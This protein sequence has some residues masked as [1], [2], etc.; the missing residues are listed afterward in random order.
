MR[1]GEGR[2]K[3]Q[4][5]QH[6]NIVDGELLGKILLEDEEGYE[7][8][9]CERGDGTLECGRDDYTMWKQTVHKTV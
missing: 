5:H 7:C 1:R 2:T 8:E 6:E 9:K 4:Y 3:S